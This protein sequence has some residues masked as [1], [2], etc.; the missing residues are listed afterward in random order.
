MSYPEAFSLIP[1]YN[2]LYSCL[3]LTCKLI[4]VFTPLS[5]RRGDGGEAVD[6]RLFGW[7]WTVVWLFVVWIRLCILSKKTMIYKSFSYLCSI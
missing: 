4:A 1:K 5:I 6:G 3:A 2:Y 7:L